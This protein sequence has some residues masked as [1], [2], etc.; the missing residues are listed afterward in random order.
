VSVVINMDL[1]SV[2]AARWPPTCPKD[3]QLFLANHQRGLTWST[4]TRRLTFGF[5]KGRRVL[6]QD[7]FAAN[8][9]PRS[10]RQGQQV[11]WH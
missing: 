8:P 9:R 3:Y 10:I 4:R 5:D 11:P 7:E 6:V 1:N 2:F